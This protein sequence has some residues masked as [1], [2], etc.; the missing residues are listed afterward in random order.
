[1]AGRPLALCTWRLTLHDKQEASA[2]ARIFDGEW[3]EWNTSSEDR[4]EVMTRAQ[5]VGIILDGPHSIK[6]DMRQ[7]ANGGLVHHCDGRYFL[8][9]DSSEGRSCGCPSSP[10]DRRALTRSGMGPQPNV[11]IA[12]RLAS[13]PGVGIFRMRSVSWRFAENAMALKEEIGSNYEGVVW[14]ISLHQVKVTTGVTYVK[15]VLAFTE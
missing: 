6:F 3:T 2:V 7:W 8:S 12:F 1:M 5:T 15:P 9:P 14:R 10:I 11:T 4:Y 13:A